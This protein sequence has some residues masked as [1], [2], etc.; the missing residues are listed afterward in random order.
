[1]FDPLL[2]KSGPSGTTVAGHSRDVVAAA[3]KMFGSERE[4]T[5]LAEAWARLFRVEQSG[6][7]EMIRH[8][9]AAAFCHDLGKASDSFQGLM[10]HGRKQ[11]FRHEQLSLLI[12]QQR[13]MRAWLRSGGLDEQLIIAAVAGHHL[14][15]DSGGGNLL[16]EMDAGAGGGSVQLLWLDPELQSLRAEASERLGL[17]SPPAELDLRWSFNGGQNNL[18]DV[19]QRLVADLEDL[20]FDMDDDPPRKRLALAVRSALIASDAAGSGLVRNRLPLEWIERAFAGH[21]DGELIRREIIDT[22]LAGSGLDRSMFNEFQKACGDVQ[23]VPERALLLAPCGSGKTLAAWNW[24][25]TRCDERPRGAAIFLYPTRG[26]ATEGY[27]DYAGLA[28]AEFAQLVHGTSDLDLDDILPDESDEDRVAQRRLYALRQW[29]KR[30]F[31]ATVDQFLGFVQNQYASTCHLPLLVDAAVVIDEVHAFDGGML[32]AL[33]TFLKEVD[34]PVLC[35]TA[36]L[37][38]RRRGYLEQA[39]LRVVEGLALDGQAS[40]LMRAATHRRYA[41]ERVADADEARRR[42]EEALA[43]GQRVLWVVNTVDRCQQIARQFA[44]DAAAENLNTP[45][46]VPL[47]CYH[48]RFRLDDRKRV[49]RQ[50]VKAFKPPRDGAVLA[51]TTQVCEMSLDLDADVLVT[52]LC[53]SSSLVQ[54]MGRCCRDRE[55]HVSGRVGRVLVYPPSN[56]EGR[57]A[58]LPYQREELEAADELLTRM[59][60]DTPVSQQQLE[61]WLDG[62][63]TPPETLR[64][65]RF[66]ASAVWASAGEELFRDASDLSRPALRDED[67]E[68][69]RRRKNSG[70]PWTA[71]GLV[72]QVPKALV[73][74]HGEYDLPKWLHMICRGT[75][76]P[77]L[78]HC[79]EEVPLPLIV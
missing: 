61:G 59:I 15:L 69:Y 78:G 11:V 51:V 10:H 49:H 76:R 12:L 34:V 60:R 45:D 19:R 62:I 39:G 53:P 7:P 67:L 5:R 22:R 21:L 30:I 29:P 79:A 26:T 38:P 73:Q 55:A 1:M 36:T 32:S 70:K 23:R 63:N 42:V 33:E 24:I 25:A 44:V 71:E 40:E 3:G 54:R 16:A 17:A 41:V 2:A 66:F 52:E 77:G 13:A 58:P 75:Y 48:S 31:S 28:G 47:H 56:A 72:M 43:A 8:T 64:A 9:V 37:S 68:S 14:K 65:C 35:M 20:S 57:A 74:P 4:P 27:H 6:I 18:H 46:G 50:V